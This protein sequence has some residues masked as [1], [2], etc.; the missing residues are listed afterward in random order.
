MEQFL[1]SAFT[2]K[3]A[4]AYN[5]LKAVFNH[6]IMDFTP[7]PV[8]KTSEAANI[9]TPIT[10]FG[11]GNDVIFPGVKMIKRAKKIFP[12]LKQSFLLPDSKHVQN[13]QDNSKIAS[14]ILKD[15]ASL[16]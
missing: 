15:L 10:L 1:D 3:D 8:I 2:E 13:K 12:S 9:Q 14:I 16:R 5:Y 4:F 7:V 6:F 11:A